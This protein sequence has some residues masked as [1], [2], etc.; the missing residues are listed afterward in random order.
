MEGRI[1]KG[2]GG[3]YYVSD[4]QSVTMGS[5]RGILKRGKDILYVGDIVE[6]EIRPE[7]GDCIITA[8]RERKNFLS[9]PPVSNL[10]MLVAVYAAAMPAPNYLMTDKLT[11]AAIS[12][13]IDVAV[14]MT[15]ADLADDKAV[16][17]FSERYEKVFPAV[18]VNGQTGEGIDDLMEII[19][20]RNVA[21]AG[22]SGVGKSTLTARITGRSD[23]E[24]GGVSDRTRRGKHT[25]RH[26]EIFE[27]EGGTNL[28]DTPGFS[29]LDLR[30]VEDRDVA[31]LFPE[32]AEYSGMCR[33]SDCMHLRE[34]GCAVKNALAEGK[35]SAGRYDSYKAIIDEVRKW[36]K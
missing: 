17:E 30:G 33:Y 35:I 9:R 10:D 3:F 4:G 29:S 36:R 12:R 28:Y 19:H 18:I 8:V 1:V 26:V 23:I 25:T 14:C 7:D 16:K 5:A 32:M 13:G 24:T 21:F 11:A 2:V 20:G 27:L 34:P 6:Y 15:K 31:G 22:Q